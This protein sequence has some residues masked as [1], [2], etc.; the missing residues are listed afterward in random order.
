MPSILCAAITAIVAGIISIFAVVETGLVP[1]SS[2]RFFNP[3]PM[4]SSTVVGPVTIED[5][6]AKIDTLESLA[7][8]INFQLFLEDQE[9]EREWMRANPQPFDDV[10]GTWK[11]TA[12][13]T[14]TTKPSFIWTVE[15]G[16]GDYFVCIFKNLA[17]ACVLI[18]SEL[19]QLVNGWILE[20]PPVA[21]R[22]KPVIKQKHLPSEKELLKHH[23]SG[24]RFP[25]KSTTTTSSPSPASIPLPPSPTSSPAPSP[26]ASPAPSPA[27]SAAASPALSPAASPAP[28]PAASPAPAPAPAPAASP[29]SS[30][31]ASPAPSSPPPP[32]P[33]PAP[34]AAP[35]VVSRLRPEAPAFVP[36]KDPRAQH[37]PSTMTPAEM[38]AKYA[39]HGTKAPGY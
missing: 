28:S 16:F 29:A 10:Q 6:L 36:M 23:F 2:F 34:A 5:L 4:P 1:V 38:K 7:A 12:S 17:M 27:P 8:Q 18:L 32:P 15:P 14:T 26:A 19:S 3:F 21:P 30:P 37:W 25:R 35:R 20:N 22:P 39:Q 9:E 31:A 11:P 33:A 24:V 13:T